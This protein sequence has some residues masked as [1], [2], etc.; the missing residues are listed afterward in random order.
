MLGSSWNVGK[1]ILS[2][3]L[4]SCALRAHCIR[5]M[6]T[7]TMC[8]RELAHVQKPQIGASHPCVQ[9]PV[10]SRSVRQSSTEDCSKRRGSMRPKLTVDN[11]YSPGTS[12]SA[13]E[14]W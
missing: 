1:S 9:G 5:P 13:V 4:S 2:D 8:D 11:L 3:T 6:S 7:I 10:M 12:Y 14:S